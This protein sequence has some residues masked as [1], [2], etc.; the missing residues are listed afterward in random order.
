[1]NAREA[2]L[3]RI[4]DAVAGSPD[5]PE[6]PRDYR[7]LYDDTP[8]ARLV[9]FA[10]I[11]RDYRAELHRVAT[12]DLAETVAER[13]RALGVERLL[14]A[15]GL[16]NDARPGGVDAVSDD[17][18]SPEA[19]DR[20]DAVLTECVVAIAE[21]GTIVL[22][23][24]RGQGRRAI[25]LVPDVHLCIVRADQVVGL[26]PEAIARLGE[27]VSEGRPL[28]WISGPSAT[29][30]IELV[31]VEGVHGPRTLEVF[32]VEPDA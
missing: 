8:E 22:D 11:V 6:P 10:E 27:A 7:A 24:G 31:R 30:D 20:V 2:I 13:C 14:V 15:D 9:R 1:M 28:T 5:A 21:T 29:S 16:R 19:L 23:G 3:A 12:A 25:T 18:L 26:V 4:R 32:L 17:A